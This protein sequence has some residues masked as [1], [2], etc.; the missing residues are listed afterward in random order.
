MRIR[1]GRQ[2][3]PEEIGPVGTPP[4]ESGRPRVRPSESTD[5][6]EADKGA[7]DSGRGPN[8]LELDAAQRAA[9]DHLAALL[10][11]RGRPRR[12]SGGVYLH[13]PPGRGK[14]MLMD[15]FSATASTKRK[16][17]WHFHE[18]FAHLH[19]AATTTSAVGD[20]VTRLI[21]DAELVC[22][23]EFHVHDIG[24]AMLIARLLDA[25]FDRRVPL[26]VTS[27]YPPA[28]LLPNPLFHD[29]FLPAIAR[30]TER[31]TVVAL[32]GPRDYRRLRAGDTRHRAT[33]PVVPGGLRNSWADRA[34]IQGAPTE[35]ADLCTGF[36][37]GDYLAGAA[38]SFAGV[39]VVRVGVREFT[40]RSIDNRT[41]AADF[42]E[43]CGAGLSA[44]D[45]VALAAR[46][47]RWIVVGV[48]RLC[49]VPPDQVMRW[50]NLVDVLYDADRML[51]VHA[52]VP[53]AELATGVAPVAGVADL[54]RTVSRLY[55]ISHD[56]DARAG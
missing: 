56:G 36:A 37:A 5:E 40:V 2:S 29:R 13:G 17:R 32:D 42:A 53:L 12:G 4:G 31:M 8:G 35:G 28:D 34:Q 1:A 14:T 45:Y 27:N 33:E 43:L 10:D 15:R 16:R 22:F 39:T 47:E 41:L 55:E 38:P 24:D 20:A 7:P 50:V 26:V 25:L 51:T 23:D 11:R 49:S 44:A 46:F 30:I 52:A 48:P 9:A 3:R 21:G 6:A 18:F 54:G 19:A